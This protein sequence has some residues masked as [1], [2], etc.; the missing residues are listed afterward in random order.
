MREF[1]AS[2]SMYSLYCART[3]VQGDYL[4]LE[5]DLIYE[6]R[7]LDELLA[8]ALAGCHPAVRPD[9]RRR[10]GLCQHRGWLADRHV[11]GSIQPDDPVAGE[12]VGISADFRGAIGRDDGIAEPGRF[13]RR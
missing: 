13:G 9:P 6:P 12:L 3:A 11:Q 2:G 8:P 1:A 10:R 5:S 7:A 4:L